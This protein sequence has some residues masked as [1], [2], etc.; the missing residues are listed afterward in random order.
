MG[1]C[2]PVPTTRPSPPLDALDFKVTDKR[3]L[4][5]SRVRVQIPQKPP[6]RPSHFLFVDWS[7]TDWLPFGTLFRLSVNLLPTSQTLCKMGMESVPTPICL[8]CRIRE[9][10]KCAFGSTP[11]APPSST[12]PM[13]SA[14]GSMLSNTNC[15]CPASPL[16]LFRSPFFS[17]ASLMSCG[18]SA[19]RSSFI[20]P[21][22][23]PPSG[24]PRPW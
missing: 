4:N 11:G 18:V 15:Q 12:L 16:P 17:H 24:S 14:T 8:I 7:G 6:S 21:H 1:R 20:K 10:L 5:S 3:P 19:G 9:L 22:F 23:S 13:A 2:R